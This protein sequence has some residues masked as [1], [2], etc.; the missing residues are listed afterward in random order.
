MSIECPKCHA[1]YRI[2]E[3]PFCPHGRPRGGNRI[4]AI[5]TSERSVVY[6]NPRTGEH[7][8]PGRNDLPVPDVYAR[9]GYVRRELSTAAE[10]AQF[11]RET[12]AVHE[13]SWFDPGSATAEHA[14]LDHADPSKDQ[15]K[16][17]PEGSGTPLTSHDLL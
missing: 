11:E 12:G 2:G 15:I 5:H 14:L 3:W 10:V 7:R 9:Q 6:F 13:R 17:T 1:H 4:T 16:I 8:T